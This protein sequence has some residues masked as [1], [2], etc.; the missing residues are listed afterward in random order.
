MSSQPKGHFWQ[1]ALKELREIL[2]DRRTIL[3]L[4][5]MPLLLYPLLGVAFQK[6]LLSQAKSRTENIEY[7]IGFESSRAMNLFQQ[8][9]HSKP[10][11]TKDNTQPAISGW[12][13]EE[14][15]SVILENKVESYDIDLGIRYLSYHPRK[16]VHDIELIFLHNSSSSINAKN[17]IKKQVKDFNYIQLKSTLVKNQIPPP[18]EIG[19]SDKEIILE[20]ASNTGISLSTIIPLILILMTVTG[21]VYPAIDLTAGERERGTM[22]TLI[23]APIPRMRIMLAKYIAVV[24]VAM[25]TAIMNLFAM[26]TTIYS[27][28]F[29]SI[30]LG[31]SGLD[32]LLILQIL[33]LL[34]LFAGFFS[35]VLLGITSVAKSFKEAQ[36]YLIPVMLISLSPGI[37]SLMPGI[38]MNWY[39]S[40]APLINIVL[41]ARDIL[42]KNV[43][44]TPAMIAI[45]STIFYGYVA[46]HWAA[47]VFG[48]DAILY[49]SSGT[50]TDLLHQS[51]SGNDKYPLRFAWYSL[52]MITPLFLLSSG[53][54]GK[55][56]DVSMSERLLYPALIT[57][58]LFMLI[59]ILANY[60]LS[61]RLVETFT[62][63]KAK[64][65]HYLAAILLGISAW[66]FA[67]ELTIYFMPTEQLELLK[68][69]FEKMNLDF[70]EVSLF[71]L[72]ATLAVT[73]AI[74]EE[75]FFRGFLQNIFSKNYSS[76]KAVILSAF[77]FAMFHLIVKNT[78]SL[79]RFFP[80]FL[81]GLIL[82]TVYQFSKSV[83]PGMI[84]HV[85]H[86]GILL[87]ISHY[88]EY[89]KEKDWGF[90]IEAQQHLPTMLLA[91]SACIMIIGFVV[92]LFKK[93]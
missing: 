63:R 62:L 12:F 2:R 89:F 70:K 29:E 85:C 34:M 67:Y 72:L 39:L 3:T 25:L 16:N 53:I 93:R 40:L 73:P 59:P 64:W 30:L 48:S 80:S 24:T 15:E 35:A 76:F 9:L 68:E 86:N 74:C 47:K 33:A 18:M 56:K 26:W 52:V 88:E 21:A 36:A 43:A 60:F 54:L 5:L 41:L 4:V 14:G 49:G 90:N 17:Y 22:E 23:A 37:L 44:I 83:F 31:D 7:V 69:I 55:L 32:L 1:L 71:W 92:L 75:F 6:F 19:M 13:P 91:A 82:G 84:L 10:N 38:E 42:D 50:W 8:L 65:N 20:K 28:G 81:L 61:N 66:P 46:L 77:L 58:T 51:K 45:G 78:L 27:I 11:N 87:S 79:E 57:I